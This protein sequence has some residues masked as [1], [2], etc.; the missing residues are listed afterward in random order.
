MASLNWKMG[1]ALW[2]M[3]AAAGCA[4]LLGTNDLVDETA[5][6]PG[7][8]ASGVT[9][10]SGTSSSGNT[11]G[12]GTTSAGGATTSSSGGGGAGP[13]GS[14]GGTTGSGGMMG[15][16]GMAAG[17][18]T[19]VVTTVYLGSDE[20]NGDWSNADDALGPDNGQCAV[21]G[22]VKDGDQPHR[23]IFE[24]LSI[25]AGATI[26][27]FSLVLVYSMKNVDM[28]IALSPN[29]ADFG[30]PK[31][32]S[33]AG[34]PSCAEAASSLF[35]GNSDTWG[36]AWTPANINDGVYLRLVGLNQNGGNEIYLEA[37]QLTV[38]FTP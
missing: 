16:G 4:Q 10:G 7:S 2:S 15:T 3:M 11:G 37:A 14:G 23:W 27:G 36:G 12:A 6:G 25:P 32:D 35:G 26:D 17:G 1:A 13:S 24:G 9:T 22:E 21:S 33:K 34:T 18:G 8:T 30:T 38:H 5:T 29:N 31:I 19:P 28:A 20:G